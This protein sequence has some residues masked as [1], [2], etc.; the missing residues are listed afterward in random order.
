M[1]LSIPTTAPTHVIGSPETTGWTWRYYGTPDYV[2]VRFIQDTPIEIEEFEEASEFFDHLE[3]WS[4]AEARILGLSYDL[5]DDND[6][7]FVYSDVD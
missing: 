6:P 1:A 2:A 4:A 5:E 3:G 7:E